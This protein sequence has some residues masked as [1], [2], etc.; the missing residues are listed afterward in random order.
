MVSSA[1]LSVDVPV[2]AVPVPLA[3]LPPKT[4]AVPVGMVK[5]LRPISG[6]VGMICCGTPLTVCGVG[7]ANPIRNAP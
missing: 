7:L 2:A 5:L 6:T 4:E 3:L 1:L